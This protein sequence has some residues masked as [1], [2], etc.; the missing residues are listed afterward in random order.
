MSPPSLADSLELEE[1]ELELEELELE[2]LE[3]E[4]LELEELDDPEELEEL[5]DP[6]PEEL[7]LDVGVAGVDA[8]VDVELEFDE[9][10]FHS[11]IQTRVMMISATIPTIIAILFIFFFVLSRGKT[12]IR[13]LLDR[14]F[15]RQGFP[16]FPKAGISKISKGRGFKGAACPFVLNKGGGGFAEEDGL[17]CARACAE[18][19]CQAGGAVG[20]VGDGKDE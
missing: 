15:Q 18:G 4:E 1:L 10:R 9:K 16:R 17:L 3:L 6:E 13:G 8:A 2:E 7:E 20:V 12:V 11:Q 14:D 19:E 5:E